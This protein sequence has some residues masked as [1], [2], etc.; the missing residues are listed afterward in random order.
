MR[1]C[2]TV[3]SSLRFSSVAISSRNTRTIQ[4]LQRS[5]FV[6]MALP[7]AT[8]GLLTR[9]MNTHHTLAS[10]SKLPPGRWDA[11][12]HCHSP[13]HLH[14]PS[15]DTSRQGMSCVWDGWDTE[16][17]R[18]SPTLSPRLFPPPLLSWGMWR[19]PEQTS[20]P[21]SLGE[22]PGCGWGGQPDGLGA[23]PITLVKPL[24]GC[25]KDGALLLS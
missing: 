16:Q 5:W 2:G 21:G 23:A 25:P 18:D 10:P 12:H 24:G 1:I 19:A 8:P 22:T 9:K 4:S 11:L 14:V 17:G 13:P 6:P 20:S 7:L 15:S 3:L